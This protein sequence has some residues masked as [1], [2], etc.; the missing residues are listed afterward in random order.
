[1]PAGM[2]RLF[3]SQNRLDSWSTEERIKVDGEVMTLAG[4]GRSFKLKPAVRFMKVAGGGDDADP[5]QLVG[6]VKTIESITKLG[7]EQ[8]LE[9]VILGDTAYDVQSGFI[10]EP[11]S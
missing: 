9:S 6:K 3:I 2:A 4:D 5:N 11:L 8:Y 1:M 7:G 10:G